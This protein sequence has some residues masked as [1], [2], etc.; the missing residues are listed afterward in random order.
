MCSGKPLSD[1]TSAACVQVKAPFGFILFL[2]MLAVFAIVGMMGAGCRRIRTASL[3]D[4]RR[5]ASLPEGE[6][7]GAGQVDDGLSNQIGFAEE[8]NEPLTLDEAEEF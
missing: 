2:M 8:E 1:E 3:L 4:A 6:R 7:E 5:F